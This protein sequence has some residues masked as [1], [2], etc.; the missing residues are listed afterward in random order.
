MELGFLEPPDNEGCQQVARVQSS[1]PHASVACVHPEIYSYD[2]PG[3]NLRVHEFTEQ[4]ELQSRCLCQ[5][6]CSDEL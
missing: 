1:L 3:G 4:S 5:S 2:K 6:R